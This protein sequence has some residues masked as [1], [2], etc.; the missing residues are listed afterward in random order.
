M[1]ADV[2]KWNE[3]VMTLSCP[4]WSQWTKSNQNN[5]KIELN[6]SLYWTSGAIIWIYDGSV[7]ASF[8]VKCFHLRYVVLSC[9]QLRLLGV[10]I[11]KVNT[12]WPRQNGRN[13]ADDT[14]K[15]TFFNKNISIS[16]KIS[17]KFVPQVRFN[18]IPTL[19]QIMAGHRPGDKPLSELVMVNLLTHIFVTRTLCIKWIFHIR[20]YVCLPWTQVCVM[21]ATALWTFECSN[22]LIYRHLMC[23]K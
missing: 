23:L 22:E 12:L 3:I 20:I 15:C 17:P 7:M 10:G 8:K 5:L 9:R 4:E 19:V 6:V 14:F 1:K 2:D 11:E 21:A 13:F 18:N 16:L